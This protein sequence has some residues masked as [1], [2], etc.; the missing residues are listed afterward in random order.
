MEK[1]NYN[2]LGGGVRGDYKFN[3]SLKPLPP[4]HRAAQANLVTA[5]KTPWLTHLHLRLRS[6]VDSVCNVY[7]KI[8]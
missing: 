6:N 7:L 8:F 2:F 1:V 3:V 5:Q 4:L